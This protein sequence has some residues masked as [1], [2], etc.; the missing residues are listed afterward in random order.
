MS[1]REYGD[2]IGGGYG[3][4]GACRCVWSVE[5]AGSG[6]GRRRGGE[7]KGGLARRV[8]QCTMR[9]CQYGRHDHVFARPLGL[10][11]GQPGKPEEKIIT[12]LN[13]KIERGHEGERRKKLKIW[14]G[15]R[16][17]TE[18]IKRE[19]ERGGDEMQCMD[20]GW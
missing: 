12:V 8:Q 19:R 20:I 14:G 7:C 1:V 18:E 6:R 4:E 10:R 16:V 5:R 13:V 9:S 3:V 2:G 17:E 15:T 11:L